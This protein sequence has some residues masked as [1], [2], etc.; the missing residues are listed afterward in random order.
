MARRRRKLTTLTPDHTVIWGYVPDREQK[1]KQIP[2]HPRSIKNL[3]LLGTHLHDFAVDRKQGIEYTMRSL[4]LYKP[5]REIQDPKIIELKA[6]YK[7]A[8]RNKSKKNESKE[9]G[10]KSKNMYDIN[11]GLTL[12]LLMSCDMYWLASPVCSR[13]NCVLKFDWPSSHAPPRY[14]DLSVD[15]GD[16]F[17]VHVEVSAKSGM[18]SHY[19]KIELESTLNHMKEKNVNWALLVTEW[20]IKRANKYN[21]VYKRF[22][23]VAE[24][25]EKR[26]NIIVMSIKEMAEVSA[27]FGSDI[28]FNGVR[29]RLNTVN[30]RR[31]YYVL[32]AASHRELDI[33]K[34]LKGD[35][36]SIWIKTTNRL[37]KRQNYKKAAPVA[38][39]AP[40]G[41]RP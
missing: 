34:E 25:K 38:Q 39:A 17:I 24:D 19:F 12:E 20:D 30:M 40:A 3:F 6:K 21:Q 26:R 18:T 14:P 7:A 16:G 4:N 13:S 2:I 35:L 10:A 5:P 37:L 8:Q 31:L 22:F 29:N 1:N 33:E 32:R 28:V 11:K 23:N 27:T 36:G 15:Y 41:P 9:N